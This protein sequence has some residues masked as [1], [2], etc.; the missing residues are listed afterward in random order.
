M[1]K[2]LDRF[3]K[4]NLITIGAV[5]LLI[6]VG[7][8][9]R[10]TESGMG[11]PDWPK[12]FGGWI[13]PT[14]V[15]QL[16]GDYKQLYLEKRLEKNSR[17][18]K[19]LNGIGFAKLSEKLDNDP[20]I[21]EEENYSFDKAWIEYLNRLLGVL[22]G[23]L[24]ILNTYFAVT[25]KGSLLIKSLGIA[26]LLLV[27]F[28]GWI[29]SLVVSTNL[30]PGFISFHMGLALLLVA[31]L[32]WIHHSLFKRSPNDSTDL[33]IG[34]V[35]VAIFVLFLPQLFMG[36]QVRESIDLLNSAGI[37]REKWISL[38][39]SVFYGTGVILGLL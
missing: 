28:Q 26:S 32:I 5:Y 11:C 21:K 24:I 7:S 29:G 3:K 10:V 9:V 2:K 34:W 1:P 16:P 27:L 33:R 18:T 25:Y 36:I 19:V 15:S 39:D 8:I 4:I 20:R 31:F 30:L 12:C 17:L 35:A 23:F 6:L 14:E 37:V 13:P 38:V 22:I